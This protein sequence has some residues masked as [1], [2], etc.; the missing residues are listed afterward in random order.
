MHLIPAAVKI[1]K[2]YRSRSFSSKRVIQGADISDSV[3]LSLFMRDNENWHLLLS[4]C[5]YFGKN[6][7]EIFIESSS[8]KH[9]NFVQTPQKAK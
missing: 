6:I 4:H 2:F 7:L 8:T 1:N 5:R 9:I 3:L